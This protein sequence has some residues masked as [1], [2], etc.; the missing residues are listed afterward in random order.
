MSENVTGWKE[1]S[2]G[3]LNTLD[4]EADNKVLSVTVALPCPFDIGDRLE[5]DPPRSRWRR[6]GRWLIRLVWKNYKLLTVTGVE[7]GVLTVTGKA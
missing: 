4:P 7:N 6:F 3:A 5:I 2:E 1:M